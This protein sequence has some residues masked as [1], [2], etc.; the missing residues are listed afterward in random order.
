MDL[1]KQQFE[2]KI[3][4]MEQKIKQLKEEK[5]GSLVIEFNNLKEKLEER[6]GS[7]MNES[8][9]Q[10]IKEAM[11]AD[12]QLA[13][14]RSQDDKTKLISDLKSQLEDATLKLSGLEKD[15][16]ILV[17]ESHQIKEK[18]KKAEQEKLKSTSQIETLQIE[19][20]QAKNTT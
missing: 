3:K 8:E 1:T 7:S 4:K 6:K 19:V 14:S 16:K 18:L 11:E 17:D 5:L 9:I 15:H 13:R 2:D 20:E 12:F 10:S